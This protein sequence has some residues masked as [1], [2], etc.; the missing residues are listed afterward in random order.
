MHSQIDPDPAQSPQPRIS[1]PTETSMESNQHDPFLWLEDIEG[2][3][4]LTWVRKQNQETINEFEADTRYTEFLESAKTILN[5]TDRIPYGSIRDGYI[6]NFWQDENNIRG[7]WRR[8]TLKSYRTQDIQWQTILDLDKLAKDE[9]ENWVYAGVDCLAPDFNRCLL[10]L[11]RGGKDASVTREFDIATR[12]FVEGG[13][14]IPEAKSGATWISQDSLLVGTDWGG[15]L[16]DS[17]YPRILKRWKR[18]TPLAEAKTLLEGQ[19]EDMGLWPWVIH[20][21]E[22]TSVVLI[23]RTSFYRVDYYWLMPDQSLKRIPLQDSAEIQAIYQSRLIITLREAWTP[24]QGEQTFPMGSLLSF[25]LKDFENT[26]TL[27]AVDSL[28]TPDNQ[29]SVDSVSVSKV[30]LYVSLLQNVKG[31]ILKLDFDPKNQT[32]KTRQVPLPPTGSVS[33]ISA[34]RHSAEVL[35]GY[36]DHLTPGSL[37]EYHVDTNKVTQLKSLPTRFDA[38]NLVVNQHFATSKDGEKIPYFLLH[39]KNIPLNSQTPTILYGYGGFE[40]SLTPSYT[41][42]SGKLWLERGGAYAIANIRG[43]GEFGPR[44]HKAALQ[45]NRQR[46][47][48]D[49]IAVGEDLISRKI[50]S[51]NNLGIMGGSNGGLLVG[52]TFIQRPELFNAV[53]CQVPLLDMLRYTKLLAGASWS[54]E[55]GD[56]EDP[57]M[58]SVIE[59]Y[60]PYQNIFKDK[61][62]PR[63]FLLTS[64]KDDRVH[65]GHARKMV[66]R[67]QK[68]GHPVCY[69]ENIEGGHSAGANLLQHAKRYALE[70]VYLSKQLGLN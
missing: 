53:V 9:N 60:S 16:T 4:A 55:Y 56:P 2:K 14:E 19:K 25:S 50:T 61:K 59:K 64:T 47:F 40:I 35:L 6:Y 42:I 57:E 54:A 7:L 10:S 38:N 11:S 63:A 12:S 36:E 5:A 17:G 32:W 43:G 58:R 27:P 66:A 51:P 31:Q 22:K 70:F 26:G 67:L 20:E 30:G 44:W 37:Y 34:N 29:T 3:K 18:G 41:T 52:A 68:Q 46:A 39:H 69:Y 62:Y 21:N 13:F 1:S 24:H 28:Y 65:P 33:V 48:D 15:G 23:R 8:A 45:K 49:F